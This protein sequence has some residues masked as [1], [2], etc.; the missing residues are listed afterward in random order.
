[1][2]QE[3]KSNLNL[4]DLY[5]PSQLDAVAKTYK[6]TP[7]IEDVVV[8]QRNS[9]KETRR[10]KHGCLPWF[11]LGIIILFVFFT[12]FRINILVLG[13]DSR[14]GQEWMGRS[15][16]MILT[17]LPP[18]LP[19]V[20][21]VS[22]PRDLW[23][24]IP[25]H[26]DNRINTAHFFA[27]VENAGSGPKAA[28]DAI[29]VNFGIK[30]PYTIRLRFDG[31][32][33]IVDAMGG[34][35]ITLPT[36]MSGLE[37]GTHHFDGTQALAFVRDRETSDDFYRQMRGQMFI[38]AAFKQMLNPINWPRIPM[39]IAAF[40][41][42]VQINLPVWLWPRVGYSLV[43][44][45]IKGFHAQSI[46]REMVQPFLTNEGAQVLLPNWDLINPFMKSIFH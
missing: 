25:G 24:A 6:R 38:A 31:F 5:D 22:I 40:N 15:D 45:A 16:T 17:T 10:R 21:M 43:F 7:E 18:V 44:S 13:I 27:E 33:D 8:P 46:T 19:Q 30:F 1:M 34:V 26:P 28:A 39:V 42:S 9:K 29:R 36:A 11:L 20:K 2:S 3:S 12:P 35:T 32:K 4:P 23:V 37:A 14:P 41:K